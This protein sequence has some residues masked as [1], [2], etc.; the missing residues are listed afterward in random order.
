MNLL[1]PS[2]IV[3][4]GSSSV[5]GFGDPERGG[6]VGRLGEWHKSINASNVMINLGLVGDSTSRMVGRLNEQA[7][8]YQPG[9]IILYPGLNDCRRKSWSDAP[10]VSD[11]QFRQN[12]SEL[13]ACSMS[14]AP[15]IFVSSFP[16]DETRTTP[17]AESRKFYF[18]ADASRFTDIGREVCQRLQVKY[19]PIFE[20]WSKRG[21][22]ASLS[23]DGLHGTPAAHEALAGELRTA[24]CDMFWQAPS[25]LSRDKAS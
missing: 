7:T 1:L 22:I 2:R 12:L 6:F 9:L 14:L 18:S 8:S 17:W 15:T 19:L 11:A 5:K 21:D 16:I 24:I 3:A 23:L 4:F 10:A 25:A 20:T 13:L